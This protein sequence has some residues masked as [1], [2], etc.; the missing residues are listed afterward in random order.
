V[1]LAAARGDDKHQTDSGMYGLTFASYNLIL[2]GL[3]T[4]VCDFYTLVAVVDQMLQSIHNGASGVD[5]NSG[6]V[7]YGKLRGREGGAAA[8][9]TQSGGGGGGGSSGGA[10][11]VATVDKKAAAVAVE[12]KE[13]EPMTYHDATAARL[14]AMGRWW[15]TN[16]VWA[17]RTIL[18][19]GWPGPLVG[20][21]INYF[22]IVRVLEGDPEAGVTVGDSKFWDRDTNTEFARMAAAC[23]VAFLNLSTFFLSFFLSFSLSSSRVLSLNPLTHSLTHYT[24]THQTTGSVDPLAYAH[25]HHYAISGGVAG[26]GVPRLQRGRLD[27]DRG[28][29]LQRLPP[30]LPA[31]LLREGDEPPPEPLALSAPPSAAVHLGKVVQLLRADDWCGLRL[32]VLVHDRASLPPLRL[33]PAMGQ[34]GQL[35]IHS[36][37][38]RTRARSTIVDGLIF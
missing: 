12:E 24:I 5:E 7:A 19:V 31:P 14:Q 26:L 35:F 23:V 21:M 15:S 9:E 38:A 29:G 16:R 28:R 2:G 1:F 10:P 11:A 4:W 25:A 6:Y 8:S 34:R 18:L 22:Q 27:Q 36:Q 37:S 17:T 13:E 3:F 30:R 33:R 32:G 20:Y